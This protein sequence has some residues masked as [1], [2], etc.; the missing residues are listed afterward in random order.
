M[1]PFGTPYPA[2]PCR[3]EPAFSSSRTTNGWPLRYGEPLEYSSLD[4]A[5]PGRP[6]PRP[7]GKAGVARR[8]ADRPHRAAV[9]PVA[10]PAAPRR[11]GAQP[12][13]AAR[14]GGGRWQRGVEQCGRR[15][16]RIA[17][18][19]ARPAAAAA[20][21]ARRRLRVASQLD[22]FGRADEFRRR[23]GAGLG[24]SIARWI[25][26]SHGGDISATNHERGGASFVAELPGGPGEPPT[27][28]TCCCCCRPRPAC[29]P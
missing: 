26:R 27:S 12:P 25:V 8:V 9:R 14:R 10:P 16:R 13:A 3:R 21:G 7:A 4:V 28:C 15:V 20:H 29:S 5:E 18:G 11:S 24:L 2:V 17:A 6:H 22:R 19:Q 23:G 1:V